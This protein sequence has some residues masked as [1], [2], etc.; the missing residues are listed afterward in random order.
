[1]S[2]Y[3]TNISVSLYLYTCHGGDHSQKSIFFCS[4][5]RGMTQK[6]SIIGISCSWHTHAH[7]LSKSGC[8]R[9]CT[10][11]HLAGTT[12][13]QAG[14]GTAWPKAAE[15]LMSQTCGKA[16]R[17]PKEVLKSNFPTSGD[18]KE[19]LSRESL[20]KKRKTNVWIWK[21][22]YTLGV[23]GYSLFSLF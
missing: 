4:W 17:L 22:T 15:M 21:C 5:R 7:A 13:L 11:L 14:T 9:T 18:A 2:G 3:V 6:R 12:R 23:Q 16:T 8:P 20:N 19:G 10:C 1:M